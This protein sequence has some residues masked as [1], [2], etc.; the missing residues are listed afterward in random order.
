MILREIVLPTC[1]EIR[2]RVVAAPLVGEVVGA[3]SHVAEGLLVAVACLVGVGEALGT[4]SSVV[5]PS[6]GMVGLSGLL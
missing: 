3:G 1:A 4:Q 6:L 2:L 5:L